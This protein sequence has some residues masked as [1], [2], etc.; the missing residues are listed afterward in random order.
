MAIAAQK[1]FDKGIRATL[2]RFIEPVIAYFAWKW[3][4]DIALQRGLSMEDFLLHTDR[5]QRRDMLFETV[6]RE[7]CHPYQHLFFRKRRA[8]YY[9]VERALRGFYVPDY[10]RREASDRLAADTAEVMENWNSHMY[11]NY[12]SDMT[13][14]TRYTAMHRLIP[15]EIFNL[16]GLLRGEA[17]DRYF[18]NEV[19]LDDYTPE[20]DKWAEDPFRRFNLDTE[21]GKRGFEAEVNRFIDLYPGTIVRDGEQFNFKEY[22]TRNAIAEG[23]DLSKFDPEY[24]EDIEEQMLFEEIDVTSQ[25][26][27]EKKI[28]KSVLGTEFP[29]RL[30]SKYRRVLM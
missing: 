6:N 5:E 2:F 12:Y 4:R 20:D 30:K 9:K 18:M 21:E 8:R 17:W 13:P 22:Y 23:K 25:A 16:Y 29:A 24:V 3:P 19:D 10:L 15:L 27:L 7:S 28:G 26:F 1:M 11:Q 14:A